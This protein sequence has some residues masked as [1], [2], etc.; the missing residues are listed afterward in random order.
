MVSRKSFNTLLQV[1]LK[2]DVNELTV[3]EAAERRTAAFLDAREWREYEV[4]HIEN[5]IYIGY[6][7][8]VITAINS[9]P[10][11]NEIIVYCS[12]GKRSEDITK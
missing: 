1:M 4:S 8:F 10:K 9:I 12:I 7:Q 3:S 6:K 11:D 5:A 2:H